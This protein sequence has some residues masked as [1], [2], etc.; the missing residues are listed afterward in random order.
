MNKR[1]LAL[2]G[3][4]IAF[5]VIFYFLFFFEGDD[6]QVKP[7][8][9][10]ESSQAAV[11]PVL[12]PEISALEPSSNLEK[13]SLSVTMGAG[14]GH[15]HFLSQFYPKSKKSYMQLPTLLK[16]SPRFKILDWQ[17]KIEGIFRNV[18]FRA[19]GDY[20]WVKQGRAK[21]LANQEEGAKEKIQG[22]LFDADAAVGIEMKMQK[23]KFVPIIGYL[24]SYQKLTESQQIA[25]RI[26]IEEESKFHWFGPFLGLNLALQPLRKLRF[27]V[28]YSYHFVQVRQAIQEEVARL[29]S[30][31]SPYNLALYHEGKD[32]SGHRSFV[33]TKFLLSPSWTLGLTARYQI[34]NS[35]RENA[36]LKADGSL[37]NHPPY[38]GYYSVQWWS[39][40][41]FLDLSYEF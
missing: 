16:S 20:G 24:Y 3:L 5:I 12:P 14:M 13:L 18:Y 4:L 11:S 26:S 35:S 30:P 22:S 2:V 1:K 8:A 29:A 32:G 10:A 31:S 9:K 41:S 15:E 6:C 21:Q 28:G 34:F 36:E 39:F 37:S 7:N 23:M 27:D 33:G 40:Q 17:G 25:G 19:G 38:F